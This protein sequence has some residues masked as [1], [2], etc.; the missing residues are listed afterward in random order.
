MKIKILKVD[1]EF[2]N[3]AKIDAKKEGMTMQGYIAKLIKQG[4]VK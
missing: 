3:K 4:L 1:E 2:H